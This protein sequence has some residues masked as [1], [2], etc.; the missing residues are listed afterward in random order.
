MKSWPK[1]EISLNSHEIVR[2]QQNFRV[3]KVKV[4]VGSNIV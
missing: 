3:Q 4:G 1:S 2:V